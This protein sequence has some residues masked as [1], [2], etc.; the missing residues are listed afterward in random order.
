MKIKWILIALLA[1]FVLDLAGGDEI[2]A[3]QAAL[4]RLEELYIDALKADQKRRDDVKRERAKRK[5][6]INRHTID[7]DDDDDHER[8]RRRSELRKLAQQRRESNRT[9]LELKKKLEPHIFNHQTAAD[10]LA[11]KLKSLGVRN[12]FSYYAKQMTRTYEVRGLDSDFKNETFRLQK[13]FDPQELFVFISFDLNRLIA[14]GIDVTSAD[15]VP[16]NYKNYSTFF[17]FYEDLEF[18]RDMTGNFGKA[19]NDSRTCQSEMERRC[20]RMETAARHLDSL[21]HK[22]DPAFADKMNV[23]KLTKALTEHME[24]Y[25]FEKS[26]FLE[27]FSKKRSN[28]RIS[29]PSD[30]SSKKIKSEFGTQI[31]MMDEVAAYLRICEPGDE[32]KTKRKNRR[33]ARQKKK[34]EP[35][36]ARFFANN[37]APAPIPQ[38]DED[39]KIDE[40]E[41]TD[42]SPAEMRKIRAFTVEL[43]RFREE[44]CGTIVASSDGIAPEYIPILKKT[45]TAAQQNLFDETFNEQKAKG[46]DVEDCAAAGYYKVRANELNKQYLPTDAEMKQIRK[47]M[48]QIKNGDISS[49]EKTKE[50]TEEKTDQKP[51][52]KPVKQEQPQTTED[53]WG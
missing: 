28:I 29:K 42:L 41:N 43:N 31:K 17:R 15:P 30:E 24:K 10:A 6:R 1:V 49:P 35:E 7:D 52:A 18:Y 40:E 14:N 11:A 48:E 47:A 12:S 23:I 39:E 46:R 9:L 44:Y 2:R 27:D 34:A 37:A 25:V 33:K 8:D 26:G 36:F 45:M 53:D 50:Q 4:E 38:D 19:K 22:N 20:K 21:L 32:S 13:A 3:Y 16:D 5:N 51:A